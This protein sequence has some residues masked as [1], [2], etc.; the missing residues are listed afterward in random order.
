MAKDSIRA[1]IDSLRQRPPRGPVRRPEFYAHLLRRFGPA[2]FVLAGGGVLR[3]V[4]QSVRGS[5]VLPKPGQGI[6]M[7]GT[8][9]DHRIGHRDESMQIERTGPAAADARD[10]KVM[11][12]RDLIAQLTGDD[13]GASQAEGARLGGRG[14]HQ[15]MNKSSSM[16]SRSRCQGMIPAPAAICRNAVTSACGPEIVSRWCSQ[17]V[18]ASRSGAPFSGLS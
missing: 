14:R 6:R 18:W 9:L 10:S 3:D 7:V 8:Q 1:A 4:A 16:R 5:P 15:Q 2:A 12:L 11:P 13:A 17:S